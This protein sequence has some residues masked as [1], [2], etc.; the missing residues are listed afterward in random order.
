MQKLLAHHKA[1]EEEEVG[2]TNYRFEGGDED[3]VTQVRYEEVIRHGDVVEIEYD[4]DGSDSKH[5]DTEMDLG[6][7]FSYGESPPHHVFGRVLAYHRQSKTEFE[8]RK[9]QTFIS[10]LSD[11]Q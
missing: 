11:S 1:L 6:R 9:P 4:E 10:P 8:G 3:I 7:S 2:C 5:A